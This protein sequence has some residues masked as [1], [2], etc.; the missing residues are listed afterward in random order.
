MCCCIISILHPG[1][2][3]CHD[4]SHANCAKRSLKMWLSCVHIWCHV[5]IWNAKSKLVS[6]QIRYKV[7]N[8][9]QNK[10]HSSIASTRWSSHATAIRHLVSSQTKFNILFNILFNIFI[11]FHKI[12]NIQWLQYITICI[13]CTYKKQQLLKWQKKCL[14]KKNVNYSKIDSKWKYHFWSANFYTE[15]V[16]DFFSV[17]EFNQ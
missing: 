11:L 9:N 6:N 8:H 5:C 7:S 14:R 16:M 2:Q 1:P 15:T 17:I 12:Y 13:H 3:S 10:M 4:Q